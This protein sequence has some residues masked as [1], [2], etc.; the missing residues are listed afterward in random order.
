MPYKKIPVS[1]FQNNRRPG[2]L[3]H[4]NSMLAEHAFYCFI[5][6]LAT[7][8]LQKITF[9]FLFFLTFSTQTFPFSYAIVSVNSL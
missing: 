7:I 1:C 6:H 9:L 5:I 3:I 2:F 4:D 8:R